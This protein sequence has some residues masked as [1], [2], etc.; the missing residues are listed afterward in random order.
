MKIVIEATG[1]VIELGDGSHG[2]VW[3]GHTETGIPLVCIVASLGC[4]PE[5][6]PA[7]ERAFA[8]DGDELQFQHE[9]TLDL[10]PM[11]PKLA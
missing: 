9:L 1:T 4:R 6:Q 11:V 8:A 7:F 2:T 5:D 3:Q 10:A